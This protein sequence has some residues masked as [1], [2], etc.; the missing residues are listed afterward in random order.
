MEVKTSNDGLLT[1]L[2]V[3]E[4]IKERRRLRIHNS[5]EKSLQIDAQHREFVEQQLIKFVDSNKAGH[6]SL[7]FMHRILAKIKK[8]GCGLTESEMVQIANLLPESDV[9]LYLIVENIEERLSSEQQEGLK[10]LIRE[11]LDSVETR[12]DE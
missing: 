12:N 1:N 3:V 11:A 8:L 2:E 9:E 7:A 4:L 6:V 5:A 10:Q